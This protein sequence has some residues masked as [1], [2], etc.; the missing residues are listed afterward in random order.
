MFRY[1]PRRIPFLIPAVFILGV[2]ASSAIGGLG[3]LG[4]GLVFFIPLLLFKMFFAF[5]FFSMFFGFARNWKGPRAY[6]PRR[7]R[8]ERQEPTQEDEDWASAMRQARKE[9]DD[10]FPEA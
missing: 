4:L 5:M 2:L 1:F 10:L 6:G 7:P 3:G 9:V 8:P